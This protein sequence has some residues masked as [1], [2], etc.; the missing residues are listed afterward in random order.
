M[1]GDFGQKYLVSSTGILCCNLLY[2]VRGQNK[3]QVFRSKTSFHRFSKSFRRKSTR[4]NQTDDLSSITCDL[5]V[6]R[7]PEN[8][9]AFRS[10]VQSHTEHREN[11]SINF[12]FSFSK[13]THK[14]GNLTMDF[15]G[16]PH[17]SSTCFDQQL[18]A[19][20]VNDS[21]RRLIGLICDG[22]VFPL[23]RRFP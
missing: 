1:V 17:A 13:V 16:K 12:V 23:F 14:S 18:S 7:R 21:N 19:F 5:V 11:E 4:R 15:S 20:Y 2:K 22:G 10:N 8:T 9:N 6:S 3:K